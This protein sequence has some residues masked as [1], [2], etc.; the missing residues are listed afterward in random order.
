MEEPLKR[1]EEAVKAIA[2]RDSETAAFIAGIRSVDGYN[3]REIQ[4]TNRMSYHSWGLALD[5]QGNAR[6]QPVYWLWERARTE[7]WMLIPPEKR[8]K[9]PDAVIRAFENH[10]FIWG[11]K[12]ELYDDMHFE[13][14]PELHELNR[15][16]ASLSRSRLSQGSQELHHIIPLQ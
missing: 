16:A 1:V 10:G 5:I 8:W 3:W 4:G 7:D 6:G 14:R 13:Y 11:G 9:P 15:L 2:E 12:W